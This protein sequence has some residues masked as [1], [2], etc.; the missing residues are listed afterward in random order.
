MLLPDRFGFKR[1]THSVFCKRGVFDRVDV[2]WGNMEWRDLAFQVYLNGFTVV[3]AEA[4]FA[5]TNVTDSSTGQHSLRRYEIALENAKRYCRQ[6]VG[7]SEQDIFKR[8]LSVHALQRTTCCVPHDSC[9]PTVG[10]RAV[11]VRVIGNSCSLRCKVKTRFCTH[12]IVIE[13]G[14]EPSSLHVS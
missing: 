9:V 5:I 13:K 11:S 1:R 6:S 8:Y 2:R 12:F 10:N 3:L 7:R 4:C 14:V